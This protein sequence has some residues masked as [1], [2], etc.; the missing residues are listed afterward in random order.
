MA[1]VRVLRFGAVA[2]FAMPLYNLGRSDRLSDF[3]GSMNVRCDRL[4][5]FDFYF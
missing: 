5:S 2:S 3:S 4:R 1:M